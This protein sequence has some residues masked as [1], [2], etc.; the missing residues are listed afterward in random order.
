ME[1][2]VFCD[3][4]LDKSDTLFETENFFVKV[5]LGIAA[6]GHVMLIPKGHCDCYAD[7]PDHLRGEFKNLKDIVFRK[8]K[9]AFFEP[10]LVEYGILEQS[11]RHAH[12]H[13]IPKKR[14][15][16]EYYPGYK[17]N[18]LFGAMNIP[19]KL[20][21]L[22]ADWE[23]AKE[24]KKKYSGYIYL[25]DG[26]SYLFAGLPNDFPSA[27]LSYRRF[28]NYKLKITDIPV[29]WKNIDESG[30]RIDAIKKDITKKL[31]KF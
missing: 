9:D 16:T 21:D 3:R 17:I 15:E 26:K 10:F 20:L 25:E 23:K 2:C 1:K 29:T 27:N 28:F 18:D 30:K 11:V 22:E 6:P 4:E 12:L 19:A 31:L 8:V 13:F 5:G 7:M 24:L 14:K